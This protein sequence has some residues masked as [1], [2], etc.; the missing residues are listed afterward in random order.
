MNSHI[1]GN[2]VLT[3]E[4]TDGH[5]NLNTVSLLIVLAETSS[6]AEQEVKEFDCACNKQVDRRAQLDSFF[7]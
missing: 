3:L 6:S 5:L 4:P 2:V 1:N 7:K